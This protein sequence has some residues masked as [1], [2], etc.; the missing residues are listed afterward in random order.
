MFTIEQTRPALSYLADLSFDT[1]LLG[2]GIALGKA[3][4]VGSNV[5]LTI[6]FCILLYFVF[7]AIVTVLYLIAAAVG[8]IKFPSMH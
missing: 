1:F 5:L 8:I 2:T 7:L 6:L 4:T 3:L